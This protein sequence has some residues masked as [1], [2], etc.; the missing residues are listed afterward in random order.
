[1]ILLSQNQ[2]KTI[3]I[4]QKKQG[5]VMLTEERYN[6]IMSVLFTN[7]SV[8]VAELTEITGASESTIRRDL[9]TLAKMGKL[10][11]VH[12][13]AVS[14]EPSILL[15]EPD[16]AEKINLNTVAK[17]RIAK[18]AAETIRPNDFVFID[19]G[20]TTGKMIAYITQ[21]D[22]TFV[23]N[24]FNHAH[25]LARRGF[26][27]YLTGGEVKPTTEA[28]VGVSCLE[29]INRY[30]FTKCFL[31]TN[32]IHT[33]IGYTTQNIDEA[34]VKRAAVQKS[35]VTYIL[36]D[37]SKFGKSAAVTFADIRN[38]CILTDKLPDDRYK[39]ITVVKEVGE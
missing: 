11:K 38:A 20:T 31:G 39:E 13:G 2:S 19:A 26:K 21:K 22:V 1:M 33:D 10:K 36:A 35:F 27:V 4:I 24:A 7:S 9:L 12:G 25:L 16:M 28:L 34:S 3:K 18:Y 6:K 29:T 8:S 14:M 15:Q 23:T 30:N 37:H 17:E 32:G 5:A